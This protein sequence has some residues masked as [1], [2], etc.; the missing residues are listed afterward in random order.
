ME[1]EVGHL[2]HPFAVSVTPLLAYLIMVFRNK[3]NLA[4][5]A[6]NSYCINFDRSKSKALA[7]IFASALGSF[8]EQ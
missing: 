2:Y 3:L 8:W 5:L 6:V 4:G 1:L 7:S